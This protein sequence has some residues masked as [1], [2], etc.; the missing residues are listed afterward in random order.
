MRTLR[1][2]GG[3]GAGATA[4]TVLC[5]QRDQHVAFQ[6]AE[7]ALDDAEKD[8]QGSA[9]NPAAVARNALLVPAPT[10]AAVSASVPSGVAGFAASGTPA[11]SPEG[12]AAPL[13]QV[14]DVSGAQDGGGTDAAMG[15]GQ[16]CLPF[17][18]PRY[19]VERRA[20]HLPGEDAGAG[21]ASHYCY[22]VTAIGFG[23]QLATAVLLSSVLR[24]PD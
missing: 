17:K 3:T 20:C 7:A 10:S 9:A 4:A 13:W 18:R 16:G 11:P 22:R 5:A 2:P 23:A 1:R 21:V 12:D 24:R 6:A 19:M 15:A 14:L 8:V